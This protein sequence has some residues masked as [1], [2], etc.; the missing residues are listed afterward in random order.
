MQLTGVAELDEQFE[1]EAMRAKPGGSLE[2][3]FTWI[4]AKWARE[5]KRR[6]PVEFGDLRNKIIHAV[7]W[8][9][10]TLYAEC[11]SNAK[12]AVNTEFGND[13]IARGHV[14]RLGDSPFITD[15]MAV[16]FWPAKAAE[17]ID[18]TTVGYDERTSRTVDKSGKFRGAQEQMP[19]LRPAFN[20][21]RAEAVRR[22][23]TSIAGGSR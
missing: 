19:W 16:H 15:A 3:A 4:A 6:A 21:F 2:K 18:S 12:Y 11:G 9:G 10:E 23:V 14:K 5:A 13:Y 17:A 20:S 8:E 22:I 1:R 7:R